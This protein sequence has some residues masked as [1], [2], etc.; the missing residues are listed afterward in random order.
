MKEQVKGN[1][2][3]SD[4]NKKKNILDFETEH[5]KNKIKNVKKRKKMM[6]IKNIEPLVNIHEMPEKENNNKKPIIEGLNLN[7]IVSFKDDEWTD[8]RYIRRL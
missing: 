1:K 2:V 3:F 8:P 4:V 6:N 5:M 7:P